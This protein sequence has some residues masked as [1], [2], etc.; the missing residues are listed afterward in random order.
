MVD[1]L[2]GYS[3]RV[4]VC[5]GGAWGTVCA[6]GWDSADA[7]VVCRSIGAEPTGT[8]TRSPVALGPV[9]H[10]VS[11]GTHTAALWL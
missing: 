11:D 1:G 5:V 6:V 7:A 3:G 9:D 4:Q 10:V 2:D 8:H